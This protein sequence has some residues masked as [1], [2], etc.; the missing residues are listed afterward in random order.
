[1]ISADEK[2]F[3]CDANN[4]CDEQRRLDDAGLELARET[5]R[6]KRAR[7]GEGKEGAK[8]TTIDAVQSAKAAL[9]ADPADMRAFRI[10]PAGSTT[11][12]VPFSF[13]VLRRIVERGPSVPGTCF[14]DDDIHVVRDPFPKA[15]FHFLMMPRKELDLNSV[16]ELQPSH[17]PLLKKMETRAWQIV[18]VMQKQEEVLVQ[19]GKQELRFR[20]G[21]HA[22]PSLRH[23]HLHIV[24]L[25][26]EKGSGLK[27]KKH[28]N[29]FTTCFFVEIRRVIRDL[30]ARVANVD[31]TGAVPHAHGYARLEPLLDMPLK[32]LWCSVPFRNMPLLVTHLPNCPKNK[33]RLEIV[34]SRTDAPSSVC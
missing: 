29:S 20:C 10:Y 3:S 6:P 2:A 22:V 8:V 11:Q 19:G 12:S 21:F 25:N 23:L 31:D 28:Y 17:L 32:C 18:A 5:L 34:E 4:N 33:S 13:D 30:E 7:E 26:F 9:P 1:M 15:Q 14:V 16:S 24:S 27:N